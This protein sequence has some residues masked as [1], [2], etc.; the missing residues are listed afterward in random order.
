MEEASI[1]RQ[2]IELLRCFSSSW[3]VRVKTVGHYLSARAGLI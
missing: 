2:A 1:A 3:N